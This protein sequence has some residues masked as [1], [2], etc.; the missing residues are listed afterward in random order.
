MRAVSVLAALLCVL[1]AVSVAEA[2]QYTYKF[3]GTLDDAD[4]TAFSGWFTL[5][6]LPDN[7]GSGGFGMYLDDGTAFIDW[8]VNVGT[9]TYEAGG[10]FSSDEIYV[11]DGDPD[12]DEV[13]IYSTYSSVGLAVELTDSSGSALDGGDLTEPIH[14][15]GWDEM[16]FTLY[17]SSGS[18]SGTIDVIS[19]PLPPA[20]WT[21]LGLLCGIGFLRRL[22]RRR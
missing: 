4:S 6:G 7:A 21:G 2:G 16:T 19:Q 13:L 17:T 5:D 3:S 10:K 15:L 14:N 12:P 11:L 9:D 1:L 8:S 20:A 22:R 18:K